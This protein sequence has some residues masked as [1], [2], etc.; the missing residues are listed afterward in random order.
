[1]TST[2]IAPSPWKTLQTTIVVLVALS[3][4]P[5]GR[6]QETANASL[7]D[8]SP[9]SV[10]F[11]NLAPCGDWIGSSVYAVVPGPGNL[12]DESPAALPYAF[13]TDLQDSPFVDIDLRM[14]AQIKRVVI[15][16]RDCREMAAEHNPPAILARAV[17]M[18]LVHFAEWN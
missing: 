7:T 5:A 17:P 11:P 10:A 2:T 13:S 8:E 6:A 3:G 15:V 12:L 9:L 4:V 14:P 16:N 1:M 18:T